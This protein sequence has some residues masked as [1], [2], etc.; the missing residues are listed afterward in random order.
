MVQTGESVT[1]EA[2]I[3]VSFSGEVPFNEVH[4]QLA[5][6]EQVEP[7]VELEETVEERVDQQE[8]PD[9]GDID[10]P[11]V[12]EGISQEFAL[13]TTLPVEETKEEP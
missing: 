12:S 2:D 5:P 7:Q 11:V 9:V 8:D 10:L 4:A 13:S 3:Q 6:A 1:T